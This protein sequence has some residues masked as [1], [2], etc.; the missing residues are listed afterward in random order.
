MAFTGPMPVNSCPWTLG[1]GTC[2]AGWKKFQTL[3]S[4]PPLPPPTLL[5]QIF[6]TSLTRVG[7]NLFQFFQRGIESLPCPLPLSFPLLPPFT[8]VPPPNPWNQCIH[9]CGNDPQELSSQDPSPLPRK[10]LVC[11]KCEALH[12]ILWSTPFHRTT[13]PPSPEDQERPAPPSPPPS[14]EH[15]EGPAPPSPHHP[16]SP[17][18]LQEDGIEFI[19]SEE[20]EYPEDEDFS[21]TA[22]PSPEDQEGP[23]PPSPHHPPSPPTVSSNPL[24]EDGIE[25]ISSEEED[26]PEDTTS[27]VEEARQHFLWQAN[28]WCRGGYIPS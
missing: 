28:S 20:E 10:V 11:L 8:P 5:P 22:P 19:S 1:S 12:K 26:Y 25:D 2:G 18:H 14:P 13:A 23:A 6:L 4:L 27:Q 3:P 7:S 21:S 24:Q 16:P 9:C 17:P 15:Q